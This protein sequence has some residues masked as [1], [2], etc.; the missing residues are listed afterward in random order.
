MKYLELG[1]VSH[2]TMRTED[3]IP[4]FL[5]TLRSF[6]SE[7]QLFDEWKHEIRDIEDGWI[8]RDPVNADAMLD[9]LFE[10]LNEWCPPYCYFGSHEGDGSDY[11]CWLDH[12][13]LER[14][15]DDGDVTKVDSG[16]S[17]PCFPEILDVND[18]GNITLYCWDGDECKHIEVWS[19]V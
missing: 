12:D 17:W 1:T 3:L 9:D 10:S 18:H 8:E 11:G 14:A 16:D 7:N 2:G 13:S 19:L 15:V 5:N 6:D 4:V